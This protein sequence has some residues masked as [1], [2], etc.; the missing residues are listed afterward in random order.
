MNDELRFP[1]ALSLAALWLTAGA[2]LCAVMGIHW[3]AKAQSDVLDLSAAY[4][5][6]GAMAVVFVV[7]PAFQ[8]NKNKNISQYFVDLFAILISIFPALAFA[9]WLSEWAWPVIAGMSLIVSWMATGVGALLAFSRQWLMGQIAIQ[10][11][12][13]AGYFGSLMAMYF[14]AEFFP[15]FSGAWRWGVPAFIAG[16]QIAL[17]DAVIPSVCLFIMAL[18]LILLAIFKRKRAKV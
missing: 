9:F 13:I 17:H 6:Q 16:Q 4:V 10:S 7:W 5:L 3:G 8:S 14:H 11:F 1:L 12:L 15:A 18:L 2:L